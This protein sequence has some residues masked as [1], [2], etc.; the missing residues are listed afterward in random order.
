MPNYRLTPE[1]YAALQAQDTQINDLQ[2]A[3]DAYKRAG[4]D[5][6]QLQAALNQIKARRA[7]MLKHLAPQVQSVRP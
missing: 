2:A 1:E 5:A 3:I 4:L 7:G 6:T